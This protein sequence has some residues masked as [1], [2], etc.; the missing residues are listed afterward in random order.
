MNATNMM[1]IDT[2]PLMCGAH[3]P[4]SAH[5]IWTRGREIERESQRE[6]ECVCV[7]GDLELKELK[8]DTAVT[9]S[10]IAF[11]SVRFSDHVHRDFPQHCEVRS[12]AQGL[13]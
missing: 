12:A 9:R 4:Y 2:E 10:V 1:L 3:F 6:R 8:K 5:I 11:I 7:C 13:S